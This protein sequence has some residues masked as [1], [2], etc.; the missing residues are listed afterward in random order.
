MTERPSF[1]MAAAK[2]RSSGVTPARDLVET[3]FTRTQGNPLFV[4]EVVRLLVQ[5]PELPLDG[6]LGV[7]D[8][9]FGI[10]DGVREAIA[11][12]LVRLSDA[13]N[14]ALTTASIIGRE[15]GL[16]QL[17]RVNPNS[18]AELLVELMEEAPNASVI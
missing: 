4:T 11:G 3:V 1:L 18:A 15:F 2:Y 10:P 13:C 8:S 17:E 9:D 16:D 7:A 12:R 14:R 5:S 6:R